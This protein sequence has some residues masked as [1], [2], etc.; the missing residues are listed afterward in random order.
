[1]ISATIAITSRMATSTTTSVIWI[2]AEI[3][4]PRQ[5][6]HVSTTIQPI[7]SSSTQTLVA[8]LPIDLAPISRNT[9]WAAT[10]E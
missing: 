2:F 9:Y 7:P 4:M 8:S 5:H 1:M 3:S 10:C 6:S